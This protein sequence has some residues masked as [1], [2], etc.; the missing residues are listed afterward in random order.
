MFC[1]CARI[2][3]H[4]PRKSGV[5]CLQKCANASKRSFG[6]VESRTTWIKGRKLS[7]STTNFI[8][9]SLVARFERSLFKA[10]PE[11]S[12]GSFLFCD[13]SFEAQDALGAHFEPCLRFRI[14]L[15]CLHEAHQNLV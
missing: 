2:L 5:S 15:E 11:R 10:C 13:R 14:D 3:S 6:A 9:G 7:F 12:E 1:A 4:Q 8:Y